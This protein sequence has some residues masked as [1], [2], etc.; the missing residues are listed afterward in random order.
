MDRHTPH[1]VSGAVRCKD[2]ENLEDWEDSAERRLNN[3]RVFNVASGFESLSL[4]HLIE[5]KVVNTIIAQGS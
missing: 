5:N 1:H 3:L 4:R 2:V